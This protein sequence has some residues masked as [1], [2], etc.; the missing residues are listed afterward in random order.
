MTADSV[1]S[2]LFLIDSGDIFEQ[3]ITGF[4]TIFGIDHLEVIDVRIDDIVF[5]IRIVA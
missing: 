5:L 1:F 3:L 2:S 4:S